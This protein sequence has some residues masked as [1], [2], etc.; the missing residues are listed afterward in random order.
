MLTLREYCNLCKGYCCKIHDDIAI[1]FTEIINLAAFLNDTYVGVTRKY[2]KKSKDNNRWILYGKP[3]GF[4][5]YNGCAIYPVRPKACK[6]YPIQLYNNK[7]HY[8]VWVYGA[9]GCLYQH[10]LRKIVE[11]SL[12]NIINDHIEK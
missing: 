2:L 12:G 5:T 4:L 3:C 6:D 9:A 1:D 8:T 7:N 10:A 11:E